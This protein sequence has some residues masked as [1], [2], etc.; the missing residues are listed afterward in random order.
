M[1]EN[2]IEGIINNFQYEELILAND[3]FS[4]SIPE[5]RSKKVIQ[6]ISTL[7]QKE[8]KEARIDETENTMIMIQDFSVKP[9]DYLDILHSRITKLQK[10]EK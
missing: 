8:L 7:H 5:E 9:M 10:E 1:D 6:A 4:L 3:K 2:S